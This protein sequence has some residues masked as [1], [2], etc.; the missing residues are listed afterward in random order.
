MKRKGSITIELSLLMPLILGSIILVIVS[1]FY[2]HDKFLFTKA[3]HCA[4]LRASGEE[5]REKAREE[6]YEA[7]EEIKEK[8]LTVAFE[9]KEELYFY[10]K[11]IK[12]AIKGRMKQSPVLFPVKGGF[13]IDIESSM[14][15]FSESD[16]LRVKKA[17]RE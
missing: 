8:K 17:G 2:L 13:E 16:I 7:I 12:V 10:D 11:R 6:A 4:L 3:G 9:E 1:A 5:D 14:A 15:D